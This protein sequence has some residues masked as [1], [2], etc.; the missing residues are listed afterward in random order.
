MLD[1]LIA[2]RDSAGAR[3]TSDDS[4]K[5]A[6]PGPRAPRS[7]VLRVLAL[8]LVAGFLATIVGFF[9]GVVTYDQRF[10]YD[11]DGLLWDL[12]APVGFLLTV[13]GILLFLGSFVGIACLALARAVRALSVTDQ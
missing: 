9:M 2:A 1:D 4:R 13:A 6:H 8:L 7:R 11:N 5:A 3:N 10:L 12:M